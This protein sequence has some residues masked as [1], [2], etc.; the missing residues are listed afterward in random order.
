MIFDQIQR[1]EVF[2]KPVSVGTNLVSGV[3][4]DCR[5]YH[6][7]SID[8]VFDSAAA[9]SNIPTVLKI[10]EGSVTNAS[11]AVVALNGG[12][13]ITTAVGFVIPT[14]ADTSSPWVLR[15]D[16]DLRRR[17]RYLLA[18]ITESV[19]TQCTVIGRLSQLGTAGD[20]TTDTALGV[21]DQ[22][23]A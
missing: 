19:A 16:V 7:A 17:K 23:I 18:Q 15:M 12:A 22:I 4:V 20:Q 6:H 8:F 3:A 2:L 1:T 13:A 11:E 21:A 9:A 14:A 10:T 5:G